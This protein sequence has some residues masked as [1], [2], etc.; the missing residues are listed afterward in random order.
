MMSDFVPE[1]KVL[2]ESGLLLFYMNRWP[3]MINI[4]L[5][6]IISVES[7]K[8]PDAQANPCHLGGCCNIYVTFTER[9]P[10]NFFSVRIGAK[11]MI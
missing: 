11:I 5:V 1:C 9:W 6:F 2:L 4:S 8:R 3:Y 10:P 7:Y